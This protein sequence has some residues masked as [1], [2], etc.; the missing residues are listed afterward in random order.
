M[1]FSTLAW[2]MLAMLRSRLSRPR[3][4]RRI[5]WIGG[6]SKLV[7]NAFRCQWL[8]GCWKETLEIIHV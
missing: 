2:A 7:C 6:F 1:V 8:C 3:P 4:W 5:S